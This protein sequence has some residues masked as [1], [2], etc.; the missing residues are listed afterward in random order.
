MKHRIVLFCVAFLLSIGVFAALWGTIYLVNAPSDKPAQDTAKTVEPPK[1]DERPAAEPE[2]TE[3]PKTTGE[4]TTGP[5]D[6]PEVE[7]AKTEPVKTTPATPEELEQELINEVKDALKAEG[8]AE[9][10]EKLVAE[11]KVSPEAAKAL[12]EW[13]DKYLPGD[14]EHVG[15]I[16]IPGTSK[17]LSRWRLKSVEGG[18]DVL[19]DVFVEN[20]TA[21]VEAASA[22]P[23]DKTQIT[24]QSDAMT[25]SEGFVDA[26]RQEDMWKAR[27]LVTGEDVSDATIAGLC[28]IFGDGN[29]TLRKKSP[30]RSSF[31]N[32][33]HAG[34][35]VYLVPG[36]GVGAGCNFGLELT[37]EGMW[38]ISGVSFDSLLA[39]YEARGEEEGGVYFPIV[40]NPKGGDSLALFFQFDQAELS[41][42]SL[43]QLRIVAEILVKSKGR[44]EISGH[45]DDIGSAEYNQKLSERRALAVREALVNY[46]V[47]PAQISTAGMGM[48]Q[49]RRLPENARD[50]SE[51]RRIRGENRRA[52]IYLDFVNP[53]AQ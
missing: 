46:G 8:P 19:L 13:R 52:E 5:T 31:Q 37:R 42:R 26:V 18:E 20:G 24:A 2:K 48:N 9:A 6:E 44:L 40:K 3:E 34:Y 27:S 43:A 17:E 29:Y 16:R 49:P 33:E 47:D 22:T 15:L 38:K 30:I 14:V 28:M 12:L 7:P 10:L 1:T 51:A 35:I 39:A 23:S 36:D 32:E 45:T 41:P 25:V 21:R 4:E 11:N 53:D 50:D